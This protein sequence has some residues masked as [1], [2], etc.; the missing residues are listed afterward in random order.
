MFS[1]D[2]HLTDLFQLSMKPVST[3]QNV[4]CFLPFLSP[5]G[6]SGSVEGRVML[7]P[8]S[9][10]QAQAGADA[11]SWAGLRCSAWV[12]PHVLDCSTATTASL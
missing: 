2:P 7:V 3:L 10:H 4:Q 12:G 5:K 11:L 1:K 6:N 9:F 8:G